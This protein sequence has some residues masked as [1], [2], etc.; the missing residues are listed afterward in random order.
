[1][2]ETELSISPVFGGVYLEN[3]AWD[4]AG[5]KRRLYLLHF[6]KVHG[7]RVQSK[8]QKTTRTSKKCYSIYIRHNHKERRKDGAI[9]AT[10]VLFA[11]ICSAAHG[12]KR[13]SLWLC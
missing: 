4:A 8:P 12:S 1:M 3:T 2:E 11:H 7:A 13:S 6:L 10:C 5:G 9:D